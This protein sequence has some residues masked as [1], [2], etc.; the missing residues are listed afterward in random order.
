[1]RSAYHNNYSY[2]FGVP[3][4]DLLNFSISIDPPAGDPGKKL[5]G[6]L[7]KVQAST[8]PLITQKPVSASPAYLQ[9][10]GG[11]IPPTPAKSGVNIPLIAGIGTALVVIV[12]LLLMFLR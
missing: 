11:S 3:D 9:P 12:V 6:L 1:M 5:V 4:A 7:E 2:Y 10:T 8:K